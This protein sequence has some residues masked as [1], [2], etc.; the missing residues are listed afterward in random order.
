MDDPIAQ[1][2]REIA[3]REDLL[4]RGEIPNE[5][6]GILLGLHDWATELRLPNALKIKGEK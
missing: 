3:M 5:M 6:E 4:R 1:C 2:L